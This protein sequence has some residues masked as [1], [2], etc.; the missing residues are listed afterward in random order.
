VARHYGVVP[1]DS[2]RSQMERFYRVAKANGRAA[3]SYVPYP[4]A[5]RAVLF[6]ACDGRDEHALGWSRVLADLEVIDVPGDH[7]SMLATPAVATLARELER[8]LEVTAF[9]AQAGRV[10]R[11]MLS[12]EGGT[13]RS[14]P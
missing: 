2:E 6:K 3:L 5:G 8:A 11:M 7:Y 4:Y 9:D 13:K 14:N 10:A 1:E 12:P